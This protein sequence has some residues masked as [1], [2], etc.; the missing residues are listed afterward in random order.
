MTILLFRQRASEGEG[1]SVPD[2][3]LKGYRRLA[4]SKQHALEHQG[5]CYACKHAV[6]YVT[7]HCEKQDGCKWEPCFSKE[8]IGAKGWLSK[9]FLSSRWLDLPKGKE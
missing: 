1:V 8:E 6:A 7:W 9:L 4:E 3:Y 5:K 2:S